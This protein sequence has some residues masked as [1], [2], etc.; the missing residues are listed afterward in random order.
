MFLRRV[1][2]V[3]NHVLFGDV[4]GQPLLGASRAFDQF[5]LIVEEHVEIAVVPL[6]RIR[7]PGALDAAGGGVYTLAGAKA[8]LPAQ[9]H[10]F[11]GSGFWFRANQF[12]I[13]SAVRL[14]K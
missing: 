6:R 4:L 13:A 8:V 9:P 3:G 1:V 7:F 5:P 12:R 14:A 10:F 2:G 11:Y